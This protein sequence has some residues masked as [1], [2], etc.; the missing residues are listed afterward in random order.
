[1]EDAWDAGVNRT[2]GRN[3]RRK[4]LEEEGSG[5]RPPLRKQGTDSAEGAHGDRHHPN[6][7]DAASRMRRT[8]TD[9]NLETQRRLHGQPRGPS[10]TRAGTS[11]SAGA[12]LRENAS[13]DVPRM[14]TGSENSLRTKG[15][16]PVVYAH[17]PLPKRRELSDPKC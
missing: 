15:H 7:V 5:K 10:G 8:G 13:R 16:V 17:Q 9:W 2:T 1:M 3:S 14:E 4:V 12:H 6:T 11:S